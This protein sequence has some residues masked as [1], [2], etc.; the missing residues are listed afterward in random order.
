M[1]AVSPNYSTI[2]RTQWCIKPLLCVSTSLG[3]QHP[4]SH[5]PMTSIFLLLFLFLS[6]SVR[7]F[8]TSLFFFSFQEPM[9]GL[10]SFLSMW[11]I[12]FH[13]RLFTSL[14]NGSISALSNNSSVLTWSCH[15]TSN[16]FGRYLFMKTSIFL[17]SLLFIFQVLQPY[18]N[19]GTT[20]VL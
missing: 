9:S 14:L 17:S 10:L 15:R 5:P 4:F 12:N 8:L 16:I 7:W 1:T 18:N 6:F 2:F 11:P 20:N 19:T 13:L 3:S